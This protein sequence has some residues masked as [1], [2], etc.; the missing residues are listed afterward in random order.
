MK[1]SDSKSDA[2]SQKSRMTS[3]DAS[4][5]DRPVGQTY[6][7]PVLLEYGRVKDIVMSGTVSRGEN[8]GKDANAAKRPIVSERR[9]KEDIARIGTHPSGI[10]L[11]LFNYKQHYRDAHGHGRRFG[12]MVDE[13]ELVLPAAVSIGAHGY[14]QVDYSMLGIELTPT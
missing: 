5:S 1:T 9:L 13:V 11:Y 6:S 12:V 3:L 7:S 8:A 4:A 14:S 2:E 10:G